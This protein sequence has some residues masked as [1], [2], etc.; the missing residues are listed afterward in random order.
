MTS[1]RE[2]ICGPLLLPSTFCVSLS[3]S[4][5]S[6]RTDIAVAYL[7][8]ATLPA[9]PQDS[10]KFGKIAVCASLQT[11]DFQKKCIFFWKKALLIKLI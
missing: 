2:G 3:L 4:I 10:Y 8:S 7:V 9:N 5:Y 1:D 11:R 6:S